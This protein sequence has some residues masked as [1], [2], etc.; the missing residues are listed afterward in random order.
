MATATR[1][2]RRVAESVNTTLESRDIS[3]IAVVGIAT[4]GGA[5]I[6]QELAERVLVAMGRS[7]DPST[8]SALGISAIT[9]V[10]L[11]LGAGALATQMGG[12]GMVVVAFVALGHLVSAGV[13]FFD[14]LQRGGIP[15]QAP[16][17]GNAG[18][19]GADPNG[20]RAT[21]QA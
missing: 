19:R 5:L 11:A 10:V 16:A 4:A 12:L 15:G 9:K 6:A 20:R 18:A 2:A 21:A 3:S 1:E 7:R 13:D 14:I 8:P 17:G